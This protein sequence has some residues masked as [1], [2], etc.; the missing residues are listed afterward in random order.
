ME[1]DY[2]GVF[3]SGVGFLIGL[4]VFHRGFRRYRDYKV[5][6][7][8][9]VMAIR[10]L[11]MGHAEIYGIARGE[12]M[13]LSPLTR[14]PCFY[15]KTEIE[16]WVKKQKSE[17]WERMRTDTN[18]VG[19]DL[20]D[21][22][23]RV[24][25]DPTRAEFGLEREARRVLGQ[26]RRQSLFGLFRGHR[27]EV[28]DEPVSDEELYT[29]IRSGAGAM[30]AARVA[31]A[32]TTVE[33]MLG[34]HERRRGEAAALAR[35]AEARS[36][37]GLGGIFRRFGRVFGG[38]TFPGGPYRVTEYVVA[39]GRAYHVSG[40]CVPNPVPREEN[41][42]NLMTKGENEPLFRI[43]SGTEKE[44]ERRLRR[45]AVLTILGGAAFVLVC[46]AMLLDKL[47]MF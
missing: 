2:E 45:E 6:T 20:E 42:R 35:E 29:Y 11:A 19:F 5:M 8:T 18:L 1:I 23:G 28:A 3:W 24:R 47:G 36:M 34:E 43:S 15:Y 22:T 26:R 46:L 13:F 12:S 4:W 16:R 33:Q 39:D 27:P 31:T 14:T 9:P 30:P 37:Q 32:A 40:T 44:A 17:G 41:D 25:V 10:S 7:D 38:Q 21:L